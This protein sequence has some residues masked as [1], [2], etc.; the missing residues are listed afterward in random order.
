MKKGR[1][2]YNRLFI[3]LINIELFKNEFY[4]ESNTKDEN[5]PGIDAIYEFTK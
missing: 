4:N 5:N 3:A 1:E 2:N